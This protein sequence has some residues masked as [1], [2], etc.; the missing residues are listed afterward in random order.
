MHSSQKTHAQH[1]TDIYLHRAYVEVWLSNNGRSLMLEN[2]T[3][4]IVLLIQFNYW[5]SE[6]QN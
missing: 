6:K 5:T 1:R 3:N 2:V 4:V